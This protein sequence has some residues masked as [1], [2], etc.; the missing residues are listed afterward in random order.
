MNTET[1]ISWNEPFEVNRNQF[2]RIKNRF[3]G[4]FF[5][6]ESGDAFMVKAAAPKFYTLI[7]STI[8]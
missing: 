2:V 8:K 6:R 1:K 4:C 3:D 5:W 7:K